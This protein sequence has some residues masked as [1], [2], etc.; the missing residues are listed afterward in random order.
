MESPFF[1]QVY[2]SDK[3]IYS[4]MALVKV[5]P[6][7]YSIIYGKDSNFNSKNEL[8]SKSRHQIYNKLIN[9]AYDVI[10]NQQRIQNTIVYM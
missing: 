7:T 6:S 5:N 8:I 1:H 10:I 4:H 2:S 3:I 9:Y